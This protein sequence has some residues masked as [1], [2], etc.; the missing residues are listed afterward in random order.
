MGK[1]T[2]TLED[3]IRVRKALRNGEFAQIRDRARMSKAEVAH[4]LGVDPATY[5][6]WENGR[7]RPGFESSIRLA[8]LLGVLERTS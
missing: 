6:R 5:G 8:E 3:V 2:A 4:I 1:T 7:M